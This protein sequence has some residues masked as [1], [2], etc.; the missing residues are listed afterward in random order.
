MYKR[1]HVY[2]LDGVLVDT[3]HRYRNK[4][5]GTID[6][7]YWFDNHSAEMVARDKRLPLAKQYLADCLNPEIYTI[8]C[9]ARMY[10]TIDI[11]YIVGRLGAPDKLI[12]RDEKN[13]NT[14]DNVLK[15]R[16]LQRLFNL[17]QFANLPRRLWEDNQRN[18]A[19]L[20]EIFTD[21]FYVPSHI[22][23]K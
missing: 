15:L 18:I 23:G 6:L 20:A 17:K 14:P 2:D 12:M 8:V 10:H 11:E 7:E 21:T 3:S 4:P 1:I 19:T 22:T 9:T 16:Q 5:D 13:R